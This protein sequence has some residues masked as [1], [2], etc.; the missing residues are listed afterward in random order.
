M[1]DKP[2]E[3]LDEI[4][5]RFVLRN[6]EDSPS[7]YSGMCETSSGKLH[8]SARTYIKEVLSRYQKQ[9]GGLRKRKIPLLADAHP[10]LDRNLPAEYLFC[11]EL[12]P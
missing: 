9:N 12:I 4:E 1:A 7:Y 8:V 5:Q 3:I 10:E 6:K 2:W 11:A